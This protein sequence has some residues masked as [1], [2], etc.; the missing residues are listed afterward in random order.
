MVGRGAAA[1]ADDI[2]EA[3]RR[4]LAQQAGHEFRTLVV[5]T[6]LVRKAGI[7]IGAHESVGQA[8]DLGDMGAHFL[9]AERTIEPD[10]ERRGMVYRVPERRRSLAR[11]QTP[12]AIG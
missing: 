9:G 3:S 1:T 10:R 2:D 4:K 8:G 11:Q 12:R 6:K 5:A 7:R